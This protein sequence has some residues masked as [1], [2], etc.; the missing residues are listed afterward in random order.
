MR[1]NPEPRGGPMKIKTNLKSG[2]KITIG[3]GDIAY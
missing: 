3:S 2:G 1:L